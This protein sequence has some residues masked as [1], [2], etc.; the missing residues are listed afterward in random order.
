MGVI[1]LKGTED[2]NLSNFKYGDKYMSILG[3]VLYHIPEIKK[4]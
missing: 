2:L 1:G 4:Y 3:E